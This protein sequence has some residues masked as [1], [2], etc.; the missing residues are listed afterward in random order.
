MA[1]AICGFLNAPCGGTLIIGIKDKP[2]E[3]LGLEN[4]YDTLQDGDR[5]KFQLQIRQIV[6]SRLGEEFNTDISIKF[7]P[8]QEKE[9]C[10]VTVEKGHKCA[11]MKKGGREIFYIRSGN[12]TIELPNPEVPKYIARLEKNQLT[13][14]K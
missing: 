2:R 10:F 13:L 1:K 9:I 7:Y 12:E 3:V 4:D 5:D 6:K 14:E 8:L 11:W